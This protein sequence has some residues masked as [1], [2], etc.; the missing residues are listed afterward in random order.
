MSRKTFFRKFSGDFVE[1]G[2]VLLLAVFRHN[3]FWKPWK[4]FVYLI[5]VTNIAIKLQKVYEVLPFLFREWVRWGYF[6]TDDNRLHINHI[7][8]NIYYSTHWTN[9]VCQV[10]FQNKLVSINSTK[11]KPHILIKQRD[12]SSKLAHFS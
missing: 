2:N 5:F 11:K 7:S 8:C 1:L 12:S 6:M 10:C 3:S 4:Q 9:F